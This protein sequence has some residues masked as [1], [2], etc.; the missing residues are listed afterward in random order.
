MQVSSSFKM[1]TI[2]LAAGKSSRMDPLGDKNFF[3][4]CGEPLVVHLLKN[5]KKGG[6]R[7]FIVVANSGN[8]TLMERV[9]KEHKFSAEIVVQHHLEDGMAGGVLAGLS[10]VE[11][12]DELFVLG[13]N[14]LVDASAYENVI[15][16]AK[17]LEGALLSKK[18]PSYFPG[19][20]LKVNKQNIIQS[21]VE[22]PGE[23][24]EPSDL[25]NIVAHFFQKA[26]DLKSALS[27]AKSSR[28]DVYEMALADLFLKL[29]FC[30]VPYAGRW[31]AIKYPWHVLDALDLFL[32]QQESFVSQKA[33][34]AK[35]AVIKG[36][37]V[38]I[39][40]NVKIFE[41]AVIQGPCFIGKN[42]IV[43][44]NA[45][46]RQSHIGNGSIVGFNTEVARSYLANHVETHIAYVGDSVVDEYAHFGA[47][48]CTANLRLDKKDVKVTIK[49]E[50]VDSHR[51]KLGAI[52]GSHAE[53][54][55]HALLMPGCK[56]NA[57]QFVLPGSLWK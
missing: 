33:E 32:N 22:K 16:A 26:V 48:S 53:I 5:A 13:G 11:E 1:K 38:F 17:N 27:R 23:G 20:Y 49:E 46:V 18:V 8:K 34:I 12:N 14:D 15:R 6:L 10:Y 24:K 30:A 55:I 45:L 42:A 41:N 7:N 3:D 39:S 2:F 57:G 4:F 9:L 37:H 25:V 51:Q 43:G 36:D 50:R 21:L 31:S 35:S 47:Y 29:K 19:G 40:D 52:V 28:D 56:V 44:N 54:G